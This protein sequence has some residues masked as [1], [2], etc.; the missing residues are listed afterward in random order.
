MRSKK[1]LV[2]ILLFMALSMFSI[3]VT[4]QETMITTF[5]MADTYTAE[6]APDTT[7]GNNDLLNV[8]ESYTYSRFHAYFQF[9]VSEIFGYV[10]N[11]NLTIYINGFSGSFN[12]QIFT[13][14]GTWDEESLTWNS[15]I[16]EGNEIN[17]FSVDSP[18][19]IYTTELQFDVSNYVGQGQTDFSIGLRGSGGSGNNCTVYSSERTPPNSDKSPQI[20]WS[21]QP[22]FRFPF[23]IVLPIIAIIAISLIT[24]YVVIKKRRSRGVGSKDDVSLRMYEDEPMVGGRYAS[25]KKKSAEASV[26]SQEKI[27]L[28]CGLRNRSRTGYCKGCGNPLTS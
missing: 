3:N 7:Y 16:Q 26:A 8:G 6:N 1:L 2:F 14:E 28:F 24:S 27:C 10:Q 4:G 21:V 22:E 25:I 20:A 11:A 17:Q 12:I 5:A 18:S 13:V 23:E 15:I 19:K 9:D